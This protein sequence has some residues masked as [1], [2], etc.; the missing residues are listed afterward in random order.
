MASVTVYLGNKNYS[1]WSLRPWLALKRTGVAFEEVVIPLDRPETKSKILEN[2]PH[3]RVPSLRHGD[4]LVWESLA[5][6]EYLADAFPAAGLWPR[7]AGARAYARAI[8]SEMHAGLSKM[9]QALP[10]DIAN[11]YPLGERL[12]FCQADVDR[13]TAIWREARERFG[14]RGAHGAGPFLLG[15]FSN[16]DAMFA[17]VTTRFVTYGV[18]LDGVCSAYVEAMQQW[19]A[20]QEWTAAAKAEPWIIAYPAPGQGGEE[21]AGPATKRA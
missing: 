12:K 21:P 3:G 13:V 1:S 20:M 11:R 7:E 4:V 14:S 5:I 2:A 18:P 16:A 17:P 9:R 15:G 10:M 6:C 19:P 8:S